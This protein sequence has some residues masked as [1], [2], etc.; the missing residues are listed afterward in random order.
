MSKYHTSIANYCLSTYVNNKDPS[1]P[2]R[3]AC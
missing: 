1:C 2:N 3:A